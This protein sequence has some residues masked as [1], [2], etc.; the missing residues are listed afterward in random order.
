VK[1]TDHAP[2]PK[3]LMEIFKAFF[4]PCPSVA[5][6]D[7]L[8]VGWAKKNYC[9]PPYSVKIPW[10]KKAIQESLKG[11]LTVML[12]PVDT[13]AAWFHDLI[14]PNFSIHLF[15]GRL[16]LDNGHHPKF[17]SMLAITNTF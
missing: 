12:L 9:N 3:W 15:R 4:D 14:M 6:F 11:N 8:N 13:S 2:T 1:F 10:I 5:A 17:P 16:N 7:G